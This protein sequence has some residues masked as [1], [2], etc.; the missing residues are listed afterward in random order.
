M[1]LEPLQEMQF[2]HD[3]LD[4]DLIETVI[5]EDYFNSIKADLIVSVSKTASIANH[6]SLENLNKEAFND[7]E[8]KQLLLDSATDNLSKI[9]RMAN[10]FQTHLD[11][12]PCIN[13]RYMVMGISL[14]VKKSLNVDFC[15]LVESISDLRI[16]YLLM[17]DNSVNFVISE[18]ISYLNN[19]D[20]TFGSLL[21]EY[22]KKYQL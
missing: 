16:D 21:S 4:K 11:S 20:I 3:M 5:F 22:T 19:F 9:L 7:S 13:H 10:L 12:E 17:S 8:T 15:N 2:R 6:F 18:L 1:E 14:N